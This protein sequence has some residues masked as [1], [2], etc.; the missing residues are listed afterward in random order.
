MFII[1]PTLTMLLSLANIQLYTDPQVYTIYV[2]MY[3]VHLS[4]YVYTL[5]K[6]R[7]FK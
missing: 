5:L 4:I 7:I 2:C 6:E 3:V 1:T